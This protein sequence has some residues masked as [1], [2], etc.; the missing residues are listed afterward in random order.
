M[1]PEEV[2][3]HYCDRNAL[4]AEIA[5]KNDSLINDALCNSCR[6]YRSRHGSVPYRRLEA[7]PTT[8]HSCPDCGQFKS[9]ASKKCLDCS[10]RSDWALR[11]NTPED[12]VK[13]AMAKAALDSWLSA[14]RKR[15][16]QF[17][18]EHAA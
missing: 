3:C 1:R 18:G 10:G 11:I 13:I 14:R 12:P 15:L 6:I 2:I 9:R 8:F 17:A 5:T 4:Q 7:I 16:N